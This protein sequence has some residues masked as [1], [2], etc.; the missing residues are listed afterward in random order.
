MHGQQNIKFC[1]WLFVQS[2]GKC[3]YHNVSIITN[4]KARNHKA[5]PVLEGR[6]TLVRLRFPVRKTLAKTLANNCLF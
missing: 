3:V 2:I 1:K 5:D 6:I 4:N